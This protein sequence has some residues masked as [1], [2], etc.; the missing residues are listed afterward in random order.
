MSV[1][2][3]TVAIVPQHPTGDLPGASGSHISAAA[4][5]ARHY[6]EARVQT[7]TGNDIRN[8]PVR[9]GLTQA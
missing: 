2:R 5:I 9:T 4:S 7:P 1:D 3:H 8:A 6:I